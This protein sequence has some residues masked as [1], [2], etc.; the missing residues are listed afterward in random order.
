MPPLHTPDGRYI[1]VRGRLWRATNPSLDEAER[2]RW[3]HA[4]QDARRRIKVAWLHVFSYLIGRSAL[5][6]L[7]TG[8]WAKVVKDDAAALRDA[9]KQVWP[10][11]NTPF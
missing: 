6:K 7:K 8:G 11:V 2:I 4:L 5:C 9:R 10:G 1:I 3:V